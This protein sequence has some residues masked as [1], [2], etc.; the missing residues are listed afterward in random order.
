MTGLGSHAA[1][2]VH[3]RTL[4]VNADDFGLTG[5]VCQGI[6]RG[7][8]E[9]IVTTTSAM[10]CCPGARERLS[11]W[12]PEIPGRIGAHLQL[13]TGK[14][15]L[16]AAQVRSLVGPTGEFAR[17]R[18]EIPPIVAEQLFDEWRAQIKVLQEIGIEPTHVDTH[19]HVHG[20][21]DIFEVFCEVA[22]HF[23]LPA[24]P[25]KP[26]MARRLRSRGVACVDVSLRDWFAGELSEE[27][28]L[29]VVRNGMEQH[30]D[31]VYFELMCHPGVRDEPLDHLS[32]YREE[33]E[34]ELRV[35]TAAGLREAIGHADLQLSWYAELS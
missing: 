12:W 26:D 18:K 7:I 4:I 14:P 22:A 11:R 28:L 6:V 23:G 32:R 9:G 25:V 10:V 30:P 31:A 27:S 1:T 16:P 33:R 21:D 13:T 3:V 8:R 19:H 24:R 35:L 34:Q 15:V 29:R 17:S 20:R 2:A 5:G